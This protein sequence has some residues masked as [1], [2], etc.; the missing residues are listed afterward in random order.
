MYRM[1]QCRHFALLVLEQEGL[2]AFDLRVCC[3]AGSAP[4]SKSLAAP[5]IWFRH[6]HPVGVV[7]CPLASAGVLSSICR[8]CSCTW[9]DLGCRCWPPL[10]SNCD[11]RHPR[12]ECAC[13]GVDCALTLRSCLC[14]F[15]SFLFRVFGFEVVW[16]R[17][18]LLGYLRPIFCLLEPLRGASVGQLGFVT[19]SQI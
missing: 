3:G 8:K 6:C 11:G 1:A 10:S 7:F 13:L 14:P 9:V 12:L 2:L 5:H 19:A 18:N 16:V 4:S 15:P 17:G